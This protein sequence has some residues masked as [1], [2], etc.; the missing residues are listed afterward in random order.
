MPLNFSQRI[1]IALLCAALTACGGGGD[2]SPGGATTSSSTTSSQGSSATS[3]GTTSTG[4]GGS[5][6]TTGA[7]TSTGTGSTST[8]STSSG[9]TDTG[10]TSNS[11]GGT[12]T[13]A[14]TAVFVYGETARF[15]FPGDVKSDA[16][17]NLYALD[18]NNKKIR[19]IAANGTVS[20][21]PVTFVSP[22]AMD[23]D[24]SG[25]LYVTDL[26]AL[27]KINPAGTASTLASLDLS[28]AT[29]VAVDTQGNVYA[30]I[31]SASPSVKR[32]DQSGQVST[33]ALESGNYRGIPDDA[34]GNMYIGVYGTDDSNPHGSSVTSIMK[35]TPSGT[36]SVFATGN[37]ADVGNMT[38]D[39][40][41]NLWLAQYVEQ[42]PSPSCAQS[43]TCFL[44][45]TDQTIKKIDASG[46]VSSILAGP[47]G[48][49][50]GNVAY[51]YLF[52]T[53][54]IGIGSDGNIYASYSRKQA[55]YRVTQSGATT[56]IAG[57]PDEA[58]FSD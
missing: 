20:T 48:G 18:V 16:A 30:L 40:S 32:I 39:Q 45:G 53:F 9:S 31:H 44:G 28:S 47:P 2:S 34:N 23:I 55:I 46:N 12:G 3:T 42:I 58:G 26:H 25:N 11:N 33:L 57:K 19:K 14:G 38:F 15:N 10:S 51:D 36:K 6:G 50:I 35:M 27:V 54:R 13:T 4:T 52:G 1:T 49:S 24:A 21:L 43:N 29:N 37:F 17:G 8:G 7:G 56:L 22:S 41:G 5:T